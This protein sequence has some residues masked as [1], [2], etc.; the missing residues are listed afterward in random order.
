LPSGAASPVGP[1]MPG[2]PGGPGLPSL[3]SFPSGPFAPGSPV[4]VEKLGKYYVN[5]YTIS[6]VYTYFKFSE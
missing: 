4:I 1:W 3:P 5:I 6:T 2:G